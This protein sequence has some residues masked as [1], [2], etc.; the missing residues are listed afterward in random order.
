[1]ICYF[2]E[3]IRKFINRRVSNTIQIHL[4]PSAACLKLYLFHGVRQ[5]TPRTTSK[6][7]QIFEPDNTYSM[8]YRLGGTNCNRLHFRL[9]TKY[10]LT[11]SED[12]RYLKPQ[13]YKNLVIKA[14]QEDIQNPSKSESF[15]A[16]II[17]SNYRDKIFEKMC[18]LT[19]RDT[20]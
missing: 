3:D 2:F 14:V 10:R 12:W 7:T 6:I 11:R 4:F 8:L 15:Y 18:S 16:L 5:Y 20:V 1:M 13:E 9:I 17:H 19:L